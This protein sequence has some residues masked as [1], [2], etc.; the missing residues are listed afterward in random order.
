MATWG[1]KAQEERYGASGKE[2]YKKE[3]QV[4]EAGLSAS[5]K[6]NP[7]AAKKYLDTEMQFRMQQDSIADHVKNISSGRGNGI[8][9]NY[10]KKAK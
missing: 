2:G 5:I 8:P 6:K 9:D 3:R 4:L 10:K 7:A 1:K